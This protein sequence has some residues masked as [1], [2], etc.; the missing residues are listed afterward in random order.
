VTFDVE[1]AEVI[2]TGASRGIGAAAAEA[3]AAAGARRLTLIARGRAAL[4][5]V[6]GRIGTGARAIACDVTDRAAVEA[7]FEA[8]DRVDVIVHAAGANVPQDFLE[9]ELDTA[10]RLWALNVRAGLHLSQLAV[11]RM[12][13]EG[14][15]VIFLSSQMGHVGAKR[16]TVYCATKHAV[17]GLTKA[18]AVELAPRGIRV[19][20]VAPTFVE[21]PLTAPF[22][23]DPRFR[24]ETLAQIPLGRLGTPG[25]VAGAIVFAA[26]PA[27]ALMTGSSLRLDGGWT[28][29]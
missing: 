7:A 23:A 28:A 3:L 10:D 11:R 1:G 8:I 14:G 9:V 27:A 24:E 18:M 21:T 17:E 29:R 25:D 26:S 4:E 5:D 12:P 13:A 2:V 15:V 19:V 16:R 6:A 20:A 22:L